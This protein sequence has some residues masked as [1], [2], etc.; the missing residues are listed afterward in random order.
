[1]TDSS[2][3]GWLPARTSTLLLGCAV[4][5][6]SG[7]GGDGRSSASRPSVLLVT[8]DTTR[9]D[10]L[11]CYGY[12]VDT[13]PR[14]DR[15][16]ESG[17]VFWG[18]ISQAAV[19]PV[20]HA[21]ILTGLNPFRHGLRVMHGTSEHRLDEAQVTLAEILRDEGYD[22][23]AFVSAFPV[24][25][26]FGF[27]QGFALFDADFQPEERDGPVVEGGVVNTGSAQRRAEDTSN[28]AIEWLRKCD[29]PF[30]LWLHYFDPHD[31]RLLPPREELAKVPRP[32]KGGKAR[33][34][35]FYDIE[36]RYMDHHVGRVLD[37]LEELGVYDNT[38]VVITGDH[39]EGLGDHDWWTHGILYQEQ[40]RVPLIVRVPGQVQV[41]RVS[42]TVR[43]IDLVPTVL[44]LAGITPGDQPRFDGRSL[45]VLLTGKETDLGLTAYSD[46]VNT[47]TYVTGPRIRDVKDDMLFAVSDGKWKYIQ[48][49]RER[50]KSELYDLENDPGET[51][52]LYARE[53]AQV[54]SLSQRLQRFDFVPF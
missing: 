3:A 12:S 16:A 6:A 25:E 43:S 41:P 47:L 44:D 53:P 24:S 21:S 52:N 23:A 35:Y 17:T 1:M 29:R 37:A 11:G 4:L 42:S 30:F 10:H 46:S 34:R 19:T 39:G 22:T 38:V 33:L 32:P 54:R 51:D 45:R 18:A 48:H 50:E 36:I 7:C 14:I 28:R 2:I 49:L 15:L 8:L 5:F 27:Q 26:Y 31:V 40:V 13:S 9:A 20:S